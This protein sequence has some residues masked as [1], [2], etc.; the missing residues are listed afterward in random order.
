MTSPCIFANHRH[1]NILNNEHCIQTKSICSHFPRLEI[2]TFFLLRNRTV[3]FSMFLSADTRPFKILHYMLSDSDYL[4]LLRLSAGQRST[5]H[6]ISL[7]RQ[8]R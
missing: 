2:A 7:E 8:Q 5:Q 4:S 3:L 6:H 1:L